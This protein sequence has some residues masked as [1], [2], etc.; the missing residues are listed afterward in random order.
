LGDGGID[1]VLEI[2]TPEHL[3]FQVSAAGPVRRGFAFAIDMCIRAVLLIALWVFVG[4]VFSAVDLEELGQGLAL[5]ALFAIDWIY[6][7]AFEALTGGRTP[8]KMALKLRVVRSNGLPVTWR[9]CALRNL[10][11]AADL[12]LG[13]MFGLG[14]P[15]VGALV[16]A[17]DPKF[18]RLGDLAAGTMVVIEEETRV[19]EDAALP[20]DPELVAALPGRLPLDREDLEAIELFVH[21]GHMSD[22]RRE[23]LAA[24]VAPHYAAR[25]AQPAPRHGARFLAS[26]WAKAQRAD[27]RGAP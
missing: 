13:L 1:T 26:L 14:I 20:P 7:F 23:E 4:L 10:V 27:R 8:G 16:M 18:R 6:F 5:L 3:A 17:F 9:E 15:P 21:R 2:E 25:V 22:A 11:R 12:D 24:I 19:R